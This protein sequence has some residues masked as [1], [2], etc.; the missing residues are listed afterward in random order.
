M[1]SV[2]IAFSSRHSTDVSSL[3]EK[4]Q[5]YVYDEEVEREGGEEEEEEEEFLLSPGRVVAL[6]GTV[7]GGAGLREACGTSKASRK[8]TDAEP[9]SAKEGR[10]SV[11][12]VGKEAHGGD[13]VVDSASP[14]M[15]CREWEKDDGVYERTEGENEWDTGCGARPSN[16]VDTTEGQRGEGAEAIAKGSVCVLSIAAFGN[17]IEAWNDNERDGEAPPSVSTNVFRG[18]ED[19]RHDSSCNGSAAMGSFC[20]PFW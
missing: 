8:A 2:R 18:P 19:G 17:A 9:S 4:E 15:W 6:E 16:L 11:P 10:E 14:T 20:R 1:D 7:V 3:S 5:K 12:F 13:G